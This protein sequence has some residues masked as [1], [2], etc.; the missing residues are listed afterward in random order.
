LTR[1]VVVSNRVAKG[2]SGKGS[3]G[4]LAVG[5]MAAM[6]EAGGLWFGWNG[7]IEKDTDQEPQVE[8]YG[9]IDYV[10]LGIK[11]TEYNHYYKGF[12]NSVLWPLFHQ[13]PDLMNYRAS[14]LTGYM[15]V[16]QRFAKTL[17]RYLRPDDVIW[18]HDYHLIPLGQMLRDA[19]VKSP[20]GYFLHTPFPPLDL[21]RTVPNHKQILHAL[22]A[23]DLVGFQTETDHRS[24]IESIIF[25]LN[26]AIHEDSMVAV[27]NA[28]TY[29]RTYPIGIETESIPDFMR[30]GQKTTDFQKMRDSLAGRKLLIGVDRLDYSKG[31]VQ[32]FQAYERLL[33][34]YPQHQRD[35]VYLQIAPISR[36]D[37]K[38]YGDLAEQL[39]REAGHIIGTYA[40]FDWMPLRYLNRGFRRA[41]ILAMYNLADIGFIAPLRDGMNLVAKEYVAAQDPEDPGVLVLSKMAGASAELD[42]A[43]IV[44][45]YDQESVTNTLAS[46]L[47]MP[48]DERKDRWQQMIRVLRKNNIHNWHSRFLTDLKSVYRRKKS[49]GIVEATASIAG[50][51]ER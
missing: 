38:A 27:G 42:S 35:V 19:G 18:I 22:M 11:Q 14:D 30:R 41:T 20:I 7:K 33:R 26:G 49:S 12:A 29:A 23:Y 4:G 10:T 1:L 50:L 47:S 6:E 8:T 37:V 9:N 48:L 51:S 3:A 17:L 13:R 16:N 25:S 34:N 39:D 28:A 24:F 40:D 43:V 36:G 45:P 44:N 2:G 5:V 15:S 31:L 32:R 46:A 21:L